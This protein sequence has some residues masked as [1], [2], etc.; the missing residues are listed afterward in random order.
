M[1]VPKSLLSGVT[2]LKCVYQRPFYEGGGGEACTF[3]RSFV[4]YFK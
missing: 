2:L 1:K 4:N 3:K